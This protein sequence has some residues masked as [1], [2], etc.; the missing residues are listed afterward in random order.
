MKAGLTLAWMC[1]A[2]A[3][4]AVIWFPLDA[5]ESFTL[6]WWR[7]IAGVV[8]IAAGTAAAIGAATEWYRWEWVAA[9]FVAMGFTPYVVIAWVV[10]IA[11]GHPG[12]ALY[13]TSGIILMLTRALFCAGHAAQLRYQHIAAARHVHDI[14]EPDD[15]TDG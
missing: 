7:Y 14:I 6:G 11:S 5:V 3:G 2:A 12:G 9:W 15:D 13:A 4:V 10:A 1:S 8:L